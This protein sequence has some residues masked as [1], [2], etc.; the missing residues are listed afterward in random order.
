VAKRYTGD[1]QAP[2]SLL[3]KLKAG[4]SGRWGEI[5]MPSQ[6]QVP[7]SDLDAIVRWILEMK[8]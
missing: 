7:D 5:P 6:V 4:G 2:Q 1:R 3:A 8:P